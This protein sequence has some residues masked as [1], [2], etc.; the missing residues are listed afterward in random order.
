[1]NASLRIALA[2]PVLASGTLATAPAYAATHGDG[3][4]MVHAPEA[5]RRSGL[6][7]AIILRIMHAESRGRPTARSPKGAIGCMQIVPGTWAYLTRRYRLGSDP[8]NPRMNMIGG[9]LYLAELL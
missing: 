2:L 5:A 9:A 3:A 4:C 7:A 1:M 6:S 8:W